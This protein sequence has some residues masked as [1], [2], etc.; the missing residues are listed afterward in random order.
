MRRV[1]LLALL[2]AL[3][4]AS[5]AETPR[6]PWKYAKRMSSYQA[7]CIVRRQD[8]RVA[9]WLA[10]LA[11]TKAEQRA[12][13][14][15]EADFPICFGAAREDGW[16]Y[17][18]E[19]AAVREAL[20]RHLLKMNWDKVPVEPP[21]KLKSSNWYSSEALHDPKAAGA[22]VAYIVGLCLARS[23]WTSSRQLAGPGDGRT[24]ITDSMNKLV[25]LL[26]QCVPPRMTLAIDKARLIAIIE[27]TVYHAS[28]GSNNA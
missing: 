11:G 8:E 21:A 25:A 20:I 1:G 17:S 14:A 16:G 13:S 15:L 28:I 18:F 9:S 27:E 26:P 22:V 6:Q 24:E 12:F 3:A 2:V 7:E 23:D 5:Q 10:L 4:S 19:A